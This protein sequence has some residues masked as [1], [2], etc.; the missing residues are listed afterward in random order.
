[1]PASRIAVILI[2]LLMGLWLLFDGSRALLKGDYVTPQTGPN[3]GQLGPWSLVARAVGLDPRSTMVKALH[4]TLGLAWLGAL[5]LSSLRPAAGWWALAACAVGTLW[6]LPLG[7][8]LSLVE[9]GLLLTPF[10]R[11]LK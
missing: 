10:M 5:G 1:M 9:L 7:T 11:H 3:A 6:Y 4:L 8:L 2:A